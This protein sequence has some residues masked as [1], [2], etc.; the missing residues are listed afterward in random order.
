MNGICKTSARE[1]TTSGRVPSAQGE[2]A[3][4]RELIAPAGDGDEYGE[5]VE[6]PGGAGRCQDPHRARAD[7]AVRCRSRRASDHSR[8]LPLL[9]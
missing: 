1:D 9:V 8:S 4:Q 3:E 6:I 5:L 7:E 2:M